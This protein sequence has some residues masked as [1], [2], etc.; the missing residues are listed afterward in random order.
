MRQSF[1]VALASI[2]C[3]FAAPAGAQPADGEA[4]FYLGADLGQTRMDLPDVI[5]F[6]S[7]Q[8]DQSFTWSLRLGYRFNRYFAVEGGYTDFGDFHRGPGACLAVFPS[9]CF[10][11]GN[12]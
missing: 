1:A 4:H 3:L 11:P 12:T 5:G 8:D 10:G 7:P 6:T 9:T 2:V